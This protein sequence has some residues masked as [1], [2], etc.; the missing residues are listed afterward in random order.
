[1]AAKS[2]PDEGDFDAGLWNQLLDAIDSDDRGRVLSFVQSC[3]DKAEA[4]L[5]WCDPAD[6]LCRSAVMLAYWYGRLASANGLVDAGADYSQTDAKGRSVSWYASHFGQGVEE[7]RL[8]GHIRASV[9]RLS[10]Q[11]VTSPAVERAKNEK[12]APAPAGGDVPPAPRGR[13]GSL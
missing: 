5:R 10:A 6:E 2:R 8:R 13:R 3:G 4:V 7:E 11:R 9:R 12:P 1:M